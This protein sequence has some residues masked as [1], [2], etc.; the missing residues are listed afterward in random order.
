MKI[1][2]NIASQSAICRPKVQGG[3]G[4][5]VLEIKN[6]FLLSKWLFKLLNEDGMWPELLQ[7]KYLR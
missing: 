4:I 7:N 1:K 2:R 3:L 5:E 6:K